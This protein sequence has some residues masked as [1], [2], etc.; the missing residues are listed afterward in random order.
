MKIKKKYK[1]LVSFSYFIKNKKT[2]R[3]DPD[4]IKLETSSVVKLNKKISSISDLEKL[5]EAL[6][7]IIGEDCK[8]LLIT[9]TS[10]L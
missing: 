2:N 10:A 5:T 8:N 9:S 6:V 3:E 4:F 1:Y 7:Q